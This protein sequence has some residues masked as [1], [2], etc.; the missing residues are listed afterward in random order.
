MM[1]R[2]D[3][4][5]RAPLA[6]A[7]V[8][9]TAILIVLGGLPVV[10]APAP[11]A[12]CTMC[13]PPPVRA[14]S[15]PGPINVYSIT[16]GVQTLDPAV[17][18]DPAS[19][20]A[21]L[22]I[23]QTLIT[24]D[25]NATSS[26]VPELA[27]CVPGTAQCQQLFGTSLIANGSVGSPQFYTF[28]VDPAA[29][30]Y[31][32]K[33]GVGWPVYPSDVLFS[34][35]RLEAFANLPTPGSTPGWII[36]QALLPAGNPSWD[37]GIHY[38]YN[39]T[40]QNVLSSILVNDSTYCPASALAASGCV[41]FVANGS[42]T[43][44]PAL[45]SMLASPTGTSIEPCGW[46]SFVG[47]GVD[48]FNGTTAPYGDGPCL[49]PGAA[50]GS[51]ST[52]FQ[53]FLHTV[54]STAWDRLE[55]LA[56][57]HPL[58]PQ[59]SVEWIAVG[60][61]PYSLES[62][63]PRTGYVLG[64]SPVYRSPTGC[65]GTLGCEPLPGTYF[66]T[67]NM[68]YESND[69]LG[70]KEY[71]SGRAAVATIDP[72]DA[73]AFDALY[74]AGKIGEMSVPTLRTNFQTYDLKFDV[75]NERQIDPTGW[76]N[77]PADF[78]SFNG[79]REFLS[80]AY[81]YTSLAPTLRTSYGA[82]YGLDYGGA[83]PR[84]L[85]N[86]YPAN[87]TWPSA[88]PVASA[89]VPGSAAWY[90]AQ[91]TLS[92][93]ELYDPELSQC[94]SAQPCRFPIMY[95]TSPSGAD[96]GPLTIGQLTA[97]SQSIA[98]LSHGTLQPYVLGPECGAYKVGPS[99]CTFAPGQSPY[100][101]IGAG[102]TAA[103]ADPNAVVGRLYAS[104]ESWPYSDSLAPQL[105]RPQFDSPSCGY[106]SGSWADLI[107]W[108]GS[109]FIATECQGVAYQ[110]MATWIS[111]ASL[112]SPGPYRTLVYNEVEHV[113]NLLA[114]YVYTYQEY[115]PQTYASW[116]NA[117]SLNSNPVI[118]GEGIEPWYSLRAVG[119]APPTEYPVAFH[120]VGLPADVNWSVSVNGSTIRSATFSIVF[121][122]PNGTYDFSIQGVG[123][124]T[125]TP[126]AG[127]VEMNGTSRTIFVSYVLTPGTYL[128]QFEESGLPAGTIWSVALNGSPEVRTSS[129]SISFSL[130]NGSYSYIFGSVG[131]FSVAGATGS[132]WVIGLEENIS[133]RYL[134]IV[135][136]YT[137]HVEETGLPAG[138]RWSISV[139][140][141]TRNL[142]TPSTDWMMPNG[143]Y[144]FAVNSSGFDATPTYGS[145]AIN[146][147]NTS[148]DVT[149]VAYQS[150]NPSSPGS[151]GVP[152]WA[153]A[154]L[155]STVTV[156]AIG[157]AWLLV[158]P[159]RPGGPGP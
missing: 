20:E 14:P 55:L 132:F 62:I 76:L 24:Y 83:I 45:L 12:P 3:R 105:A 19:V 54:P 145:I 93:S 53:D 153:W 130:R 38:P 143:T 25:G 128:V 149:F 75:V 88:D 42:G 140:P 87:V 43:S 63:D 158:R 77:V 39:N 142:S 129:T 157:A 35:A 46:F 108:A 17:A 52:G 121:D 56:D 136:T 135:V 95:S 98:N 71:L 144:S 21:I 22:N 6:V 154:A 113:A 69:T 159:R 1:W 126:A 82:P 133:V 118:G 119:P 78:L 37:D 109:S 107:H 120:E 61:G 101:T 151:G 116:V 16:S 99:P 131:G 27:T 150:S 64:A 146:G 28:P 68:F 50:T 2:T 152:S 66:P 30:F 23:Y 72:A 103:F 18:S 86:E 10:G 32:S 15:A 33:T 7:T 89:T 58:T 44:W 85:G 141:A 8:S 57:V 102:S 81:P 104:N 110:S 106:A 48:G 147:K 117:A 139:G 156:A 67:V 29:R 90:W 123:G 73:A 74:T 51:N 92:T 94:S 9:A 5:P 79:L 59:P 13:S 124:Y 80:L 127:T 96:S 115:D 111:T 65:A 40:P 138:T 49:L 155:A 36:S 134:G 70:V 60:S 47:A 31:D 100:T 11:T 125:V 137:L 84:Y 4:R 97:W 34:F 112:L 26:F 122:V 148:L 114:L 41:T 91:T